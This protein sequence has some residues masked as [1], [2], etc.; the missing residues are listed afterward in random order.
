MH[1][2]R[3]YRRAALVLALAAMTL[4]ITACSQAAAPPIAPKSQAN[5]PAAAVATVT[6]EATVAAE[7]APVAPAPV[8]AK[9]MTPQQ[10]ADKKCKSCHSASKTL[11]YKASSKAK[12]TKMVDGMVKR[13][14][15]VSSGEKAIL[16]AYYL[17]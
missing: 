3:T 4:G 7:P 6:S 11:S 15:S 13:G 9:K 2:N 1:S 10:V 12:A 8:V 16:V 14:A 17:R 5:L